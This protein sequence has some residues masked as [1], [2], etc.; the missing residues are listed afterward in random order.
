MKKIFICT[1]SVALLTVGLSS[2][3]KSSKGKMANE[4]KVTEYNQTTTEME[5]N[6]DKTVSTTTMTETAATMTETTTSNG[7][8]TTTTGTAVVNA[9]TWT[10]E[11]DGT[12][13]ATRDWTTSSTNL[14]I[15]TTYRTTEMT[16]GT[17]AFVGKTKGDEFKKNERVIFNTLTSSMTQVVTTGNG[18][19]TTYSSN[20]TYKTGEETMIYTVTE[21][22]AKELQL[23][24]EIGNTS[25]FGSSTSSVTG[26]TTVTLAGE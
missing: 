13:K 23:E 14:G 16:S 21:S 18:N 4:W 3:G 25:T 17:W 19:P 6:G 8:S 7:S 1:L 2:C 10:I 24:A 11:K 22:K 12:W 5:A 20:D 9:N 26:K 15:T